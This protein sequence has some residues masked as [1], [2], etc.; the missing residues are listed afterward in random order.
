MA[1]FSTITD[2]CPEIVYHYVRVPTTLTSF[3]HRPNVLMEPLPLFLANITKV[4]WEIV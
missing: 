2:Q 4:L 1:L 3:F